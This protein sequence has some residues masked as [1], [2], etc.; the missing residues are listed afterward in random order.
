MLGALH[1]CHL[2]A[3]GMVTVAPR[4]DALYLLLKEVTWQVLGALHACH[5]LAV[6][7]G[8][9][10]PGAFQG[11]AGRKEALSLILF[12]SMSLAVACRHAHACHASCPTGLECPASKRVQTVGL[13]ALSSACDAVPGTSVWGTSVSIARCWA[14]RASGA[15]WCGR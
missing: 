10:A 6:G 5:L 8:A 11:A 1:A 15:C 2:L 9:V 4:N 12:N 3:V 13:C 14:A 7:V